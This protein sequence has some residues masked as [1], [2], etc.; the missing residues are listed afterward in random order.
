MMGVAPSMTANGKLHVSL[1][2]SSS[3]MMPT[4]SLSLMDCS[5]YV[6][7][8]PSLEDVIAF[9]GIPKASTEVRASSRLET[10]PDVDMPQLEKAMRYAQMR[11]TPCSQ[12][13]PLVPKFSIVNIPYS[14]IC[15]RAERLGV[16]LGISKG[17]VAK[18]IKGIK[19]LE[20]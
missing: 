5:T 13:K 16:S 19:L 9:G 10:R 1:S 3:S 11:E 8:Q 15:H 12:G 17:E 4:L 7:V 14:E 2:H 18:S 20:E 6:P